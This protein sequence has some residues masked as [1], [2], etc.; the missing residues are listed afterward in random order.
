MTTR[1]GTGL[2][3]TKAQVA[4]DMLAFLYAYGLE[5]QYLMLIRRYVVNMIDEVNSLGMKA[6]KMSI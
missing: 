4:P 5:R 6:R 1:L 2:V 3:L